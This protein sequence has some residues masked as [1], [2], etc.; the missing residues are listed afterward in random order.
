MLWPDMENYEPANPPKSSDTIKKQDLSK[1]G[2]LIAVLLSFGIVASA[3]AVGHARITNV[4]RQNNALK[5]QASSLSKQIKQQDDINKGIVSA[6]DEYKDP[7]GGLGLLDG[8]IT[9]T[10]PKDWSRVP[11]TDCSGGSR[12]SEVLCY[13]VAAIAPKSLINDGKSNWSAGVAVFEYKSTDGSAQNWY[14]TKY[15]GT[16]LAN[17]NIPIILNLKTD[18]INGDSAVSFQAEGGVYKGT[19]AYTNAFYVLVHGKYAVLVHARL[20]DGGVYGSY[21]G[22]KPY[23]Y[24]TTYEPI[25]RQ[26]IESIKFKE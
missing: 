8:A 21:P 15:D 6:S 12:D 1:L 22:A 13:D 23:D 2:I 7:D 3:Y 20:Q 9:F 10:L 14:E 19:L 17:Y 24:R 18:P 16:P 25:L 11:A 26:F 5:A 4:T